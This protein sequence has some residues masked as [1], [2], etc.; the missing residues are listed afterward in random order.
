[1]TWQYFCFVAPV[2]S[3][4]RGEGGGCVGELDAHCRFCGT[5][6]NMVHMKVVEAVVV[7]LVV[8][9]GVVFLWKIASL[10]RL[11]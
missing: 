5:F 1:M 3:T 9:A 6:D 4:A 7:L 10:S 2:D 8:F 11:L